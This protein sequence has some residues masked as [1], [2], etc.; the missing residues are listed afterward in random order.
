MCV[1]KTKHYSVANC[2]QKQKSATLSKSYKLL[3]F[4]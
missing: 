3:I 2:V 4:S 1:V